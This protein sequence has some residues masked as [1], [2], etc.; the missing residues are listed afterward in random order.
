MLDGV[1]SPEA[2]DERLA[3]ALTV[4]SNPVRIAILRS[5]SA[6][7]ILRDVRVRA[8]GGGVPDRARGAVLSRQTVKEHLDKLVASGVVV[9]REVERDGAPAVEYVLDHRALYALAEEF[10]GFAKLRSFA[11]LD[12]HT[13]ARSADSSAPE[14]GGPCLVLVRGLHDGAVYRLNPPAQGE[15]EWTIGRRRGL[16]VSLDYDPFVSGENAIV[17]WRGGAFHV[18]TVAGSRNAVTVNYRALGD[19]ERRRLATGDILGVG[20]SA[21]LFRG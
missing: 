18:E 19:G 4:F 16:D 21:L 7:R 5:L 14:V 3:A 2:G 1:V 15:R 11:D 10:R 12:V 17:S 6:P 9:A 13:L 20:K 8:P